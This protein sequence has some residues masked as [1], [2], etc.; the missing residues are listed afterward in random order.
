M[1]LASGAT[2]T[3]PKVTPKVILQQQQAGPASEQKVEASFGFDFEANS[4]WQYSKRYLLKP[5]LA[6]NIEANFGRKLN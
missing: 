5:H 6:S 3:T 2:K 1:L 4:F